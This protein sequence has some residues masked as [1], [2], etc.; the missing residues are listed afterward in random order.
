[1]YGTREG[2]VALGFA[3]TS[4]SE[5]E[6]PEPPEPSAPPGFTTV[7]AAPSVAT[8]RVPEIESPLPAEL[9]GPKPK[10]GLPRGFELLP[11]PPSM[12]CDTLPVAGARV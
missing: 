4:S 8:P 1:M 12:P 3:R 2:A 5:V 9:E 6:V 11:K 7:S 10:S